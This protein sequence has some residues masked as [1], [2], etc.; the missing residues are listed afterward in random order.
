MP[1]YIFRNPITN[2]IKAV[3]QKMNQ[4]HV[5][6]EDGITYERIYTVPQAAIDTKADPFSSK[7]FIEKTGKK[8]GTVGDLYDRAA[9]LGDKRASQAGRDE[10]KQEYYKHWEK[11]R[12]K[13]KHPERRRA[14]AA[15]KLKSLGI[16][17]ER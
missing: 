9:E 5:Y 17:I 13:K 15:A 4:P 7:D 6:S 2:A 10:V 3:I 12:P 14:E 8:K 16:S 11:R 1:C